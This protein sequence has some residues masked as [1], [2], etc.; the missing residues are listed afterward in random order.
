MWKPP[1]EVR[2][3]INSARL[4]YSSLAVSVQTVLSAVGSVANGLAQVKEEVATQKQMRVI[5]AGDRFSL[6]ME[7]SSERLR[8][9]AVLKVDLAFR[10]ASHTIG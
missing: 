6:V 1:H 4:A 5:G 9:R 8:P 7:V 3:R 10:S 2:R